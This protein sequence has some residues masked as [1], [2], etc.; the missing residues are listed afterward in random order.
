MQSV[1]YTGW[2]TACTCVHV[3]RTS[4]SNGLGNILSQTSCITGSRAKT[5]SSVFSFSSDPCCWDLHGWATLFDEDEEEEAVAIA[6]A[7]FTSQDFRAR[8]Q[9]IPGRFQRYSKLQGF[10]TGLQTIPGQFQ[11][12]FDILTLVWH[13]SDVYSDILSGVSSGIL[14]SIF[15]GILSGTLS[16]I[17]LGSTW[18]SIWRI[19]WPST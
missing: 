4:T 2:S 8:L 18:C 14:S 7:D 1:S 13:L 15:S 17:L 3:W 6:G 11:N 5:F 9:T 19:F 10:K 16:D 12:Y